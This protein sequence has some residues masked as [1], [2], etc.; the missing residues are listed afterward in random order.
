MRLK[1]IITILT[2]TLLIGA[3]GQDPRY[4]QYFSSPLTMNPALTGNFE[5]I[6]RVAA[7]YRKQWWQ[8]GN[9]FNTAT[10]SFEHKILRN[11]IEGEN[12]FGIGGMI[13]NDESLAGGFRST[14]GAMSAA[15]HQTLDRLGMHSIGV[16]IQGGYHNRIVD[17]TRLTFGTQFASGGF[18][19]EIPSGEFFPVG[20]KPFFDI[21][22]GLV[23]SYN[24]GENSAYIGGSLYHAAK[25]RFSFFQDQ[26]ARVA[27]RYTIHGGANFYFSNNSYDR[28]LISG[29]YMLQNKATEINTGVAYGYYIGDEYNPKYIYMGAFYRHQDAIYPYVSLQLNGMQFGLSYDVTTSKLKNIAPKYG[30]IELTFI[31]TKPDDRFDRRVMP[32]NF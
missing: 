15:Y 5:G 26:E 29:I 9:P 30:S 20:L 1:I 32:W 16:G 17:F 6:Y 11:K 24:D 8:V 10:I 12:R 21:N 31:Y 13:L 4:S 28:I 25:P 7:N 27:R 3:R 2:F 23:Y 19:T 14:S 22:T 18:D